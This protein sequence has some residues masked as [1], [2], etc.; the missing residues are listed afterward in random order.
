MRVGIYNRWLA[1]MG[2]GEKHSL[3][4]A[5]CLAS[6]YDVTVINHTPVDKDS[7][8][9]RLAVDL[10]D[11]KFL[12]IPES[13]LDELSVLTKEYDLFINASHMDFFPSHATYNVLLVFF[14]IP[15]EH[16]PLAQFRRWVGI[17]L[18]RWLIL[19]AFTEG[20]FG[21]ELVEGAQ[22][23]RLG[24]RAYIDLPASR[25]TYHVRFA[26]ASQNS[27]VQ[28]AVL[29]LDE[30][31][32]KEVTFSEEGGFVPCQIEVT[33]GGA[34]R[35][36]IEARSENL[37]TPEPSYFW[38]VLKNF[39]I[40]HF[41]YRLYQLLFEQWFK[42]WG[43]RL[44]GVLPQTILQIV[45]TYETIWANSAFT[46]KWIKGYWGRSSEVLSPP[47]DVAQ[48]SPGQKENIILNVGRFFAGSHNKKHLVMI[49]AFK[50]MVDQGLRGWELHLAGGTTP[51]IA[52]DA[53]LHQARAQAQGY[54]IVIHTDVPFDELV[55][56]YGKS[57]VYWHASG[58][59]E[60]EKKEP[61]KFEH[62][63]ITTVEAMASGCVPVV[64]G[65]G[66]QTEIVQHEHNG[67]LWNTIDELHEFT[68]LLIK[69]RKLRQ[70]LSMTAVIDSH[71]YDKMHFH[72][73][74][75]Y[76]LREQGVKI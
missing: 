60:D 10:S 2:G 29:S 64:I 28:Q 15:V 26:L 72:Q 66:G 7:I 43:L 75:I 69:D 45:N 38:M 50:G 58:F 9:K 20:V 49:R 37:E 27:R 40:E 73:R 44:Q 53:Y 12:V 5:E 18:R 13:M 52:H 41:R 54:P 31:R 4:I 25:Y 55:S 76:L 36:T 16:G 51:G 23:R 74:L 22:V 57:S 6:H 19:P 61:I 70:R 11:T 68:W 35:L 65:R 3:T 24:P 30:Q 14:P 46:Q 21:A 48:F 63:G 17:R 33:G 71:R 42:E 56:L 39:E 67:F 32:L 62:F 8:G 1:T 47:V 34:H 59:G